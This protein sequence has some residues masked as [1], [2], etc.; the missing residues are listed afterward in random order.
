MGTALFAWTLLCVAVGVL[1][2]LIFAVALDDPPDPFARGAIAL[3]LI[4]FEMA[5]LWVWSTVAV[6]SA[7]IWFVLRKEEEQDT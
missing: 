1:G 2:G 5:V 3:F 6:G 7:A 4:A